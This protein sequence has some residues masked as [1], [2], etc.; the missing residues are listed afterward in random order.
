MVSV[1]RPDHVLLR[2][3]ADLVTSP[4]PA[5]RQNALERRPIRVAGLPGGLIGVLA[6]VATAIPSRRWI[7]PTR[8]WTAP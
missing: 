4:P 7:C 1:L 5:R 6:G 3:L 8:F 2:N